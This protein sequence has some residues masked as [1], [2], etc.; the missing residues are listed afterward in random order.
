[1]S[2]SAL[3][4]PL[5]AE[6]REVAGGMPA[7]PPQGPDESAGAAPLPAS[8]PASAP[9]SGPTPAPTPAP[10]RR[11]LDVALR[12]A[13]SSGVARGAAK[14]RA[15]AKRVIR[16]A[17][18]WYVE[19][20][21]ARH[22]AEAAASANRR[23][24]ELE[25][26]L[27]QAGHVDDLLAGIELLKGEVVFLHN[28]ATNLELLKGEVRS[29][30]SAPVNLE[31]LKGEVRALAATMEELGM[32]LAPG[33]GLSG[34][35]VRVAELRE[36]VNGV[37]RRLRQAQAQAQQ[38]LAQQ[39]ALAGAPQQ[40]GPQHQSTSSA[41]VP[42]VPDEPGR[43]VDAGPRSGLFDYVG[44][45]RRFRG[46]PDEVLATLRK[47]YGQLLSTHAPVLDVG[48]GRGELLAVL[49][50]AGVEA[51]GV[52]T[53]PGMVAE[54][55]EAGLEVHQ[56]DAL[57]FLRQ[58]EPH[59]LGAI[60][61]IHVIEHLQLDDVLAL[62]ELAVSRLRPGGVLVAE[63]PNPA[64]LI[65]LGNSFILDP[66]HVWP[67][68]PA[69]MNFL[70]ESAGFR[71]VRFEFHAPAEGY[72]LPLVT[73]PDAP[74]WVSTVNVALEKLNQSLFGPQEYAVVATTPS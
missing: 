2:E 59:S 68:H 56:A 16:K 37:E 35:A 70:C 40:A 7:P 71:D 11:P 72:H 55:R 42:S 14:G 64:S 12:G 30:H 38:A 25:R 6:L 67:L 44:F 10:A 58:R 36:K 29:L 28:T 9:A 18:A 22:A 49:K 1:M 32:A 13:V 66:T 17:I 48:C 45:E 41:P 51:L 19:P 46:D 53:D 63:T 23:V 57:A 65:V 69:L 31:L 20:E 47:R 39:Q 74:A 5:L 43:A 15:L 24:G 21:A 61:A 26:R 62:L 60:V 73:D 34:A 4:P 54:A 33:A 52:D 3:V 50:D 8:G 27:D